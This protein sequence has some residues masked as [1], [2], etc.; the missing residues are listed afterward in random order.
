MN[1]VYDFKRIVLLARLKFSLHKKALTL[2]VLGYFA[3][4]FIVGFFIAYANRNHPYNVHFFTTFHYISLSIMMVLGSIVL[5]SR[6]FQDMNTPEKAITQ[7]LIPASTFE[8]YLL[9]LI[10][11]SLI[12]F[13]FSFLT[14]HIFSLLFNCIWVCSFGYDF[15]IFN[16]FNIFNIPWLFEIIL[17]YILLHSIF[18]LGAAAFRKYPI[19]KTVLAMQVLNWAYT[20]L[21]IIVIII[22]FGSMD[23]FGNYMNHMDHSV[24]PIERFDPVKFEAQGRL[25]LKLLMVIFTG[26]FYVTAYYKLKERE[27]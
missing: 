8:K 2:S 15:Q 9:P 25:L 7:I 4:L 24:F 11:T 5:A 19:V 14:Y 6:A 13:V 22:L 12:W 26:A 18:I 20:I 1:Q 17:S 16:G 10:S 21:G 23:N 27:V 3:L